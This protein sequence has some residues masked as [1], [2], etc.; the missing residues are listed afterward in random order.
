[1]TY[2]FNRK[3]DYIKSLSGEEINSL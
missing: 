1:M 3:S 2:F